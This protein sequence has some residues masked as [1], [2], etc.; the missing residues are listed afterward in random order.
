MSEAEVLRREVSMKQAKVYEA[1]LINIENG[2]VV[3]VSARESD[4]HREGILAN[5]VASAVREKFNQYV[6]PLF[7]FGAMGWQGDWVYVSSQFKPL[8]QY[9]EQYAKKLAKAIKILK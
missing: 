9:R 7:G 8:K 1:H 2:E 6:N 4:D 3:S 5:K